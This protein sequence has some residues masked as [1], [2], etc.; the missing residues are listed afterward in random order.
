MLSE[1]PKVATL[2][3]YL[4]DWPYEYRAGLSAEVFQARKTQFENELGK[5]L[6]HLCEVHNLRPRLLAMHHYV[7]GDDDRIF[8]RKFASEH[9]QGLDP[10][11][12]IRPSSPQELLHSMQTAA[13]CLTMRFHSTLFANTLGVPFTAIDYT[14]G[15]K[16]FHYL[17]D[18]QK[19]GQLINMEEIAT[20]KWRAQ[21][22]H[23]Q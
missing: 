7:V 14:Q 21:E 8:N 23:P 6:R 2:N 5:W 15:G 4:R 3:C 10:L 18:H 13:Y 20:G 11:V 16:I 1:E 17:T 12:E 22:I 19:L 9:L